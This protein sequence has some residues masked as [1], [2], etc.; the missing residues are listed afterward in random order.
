M[1]HSDGSD[2][3]YEAVQQPGKVELRVQNGLF[4][5]LLSRLSFERSHDADM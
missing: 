2:S 1:A 4:A 5:F 3:S